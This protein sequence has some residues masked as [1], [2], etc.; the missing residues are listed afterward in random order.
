[1]QDQLESEIISVIIDKITQSAT[2]YQKNSNNH[3]KVV[4]RKTKK[5]EELLKRFS[6]LIIVFIFKRI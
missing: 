2:N 5:K 6:W 1:M 3:S 4:D